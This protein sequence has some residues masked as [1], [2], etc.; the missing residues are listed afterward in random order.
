MDKLIVHA[1]AKIN[2]FLEVLDK[3]TD[4]YHNIETVFQSIDLHDTLIFKEQKAGVIN[5]SS[6]NKDL[7]LG[8]SNLIS[9]ACELL[10]KESGKN[11]GVDIQLIKRIPIGAGLAGGSADAGGTLIGLNEFWELGYSIGD[12]VELGKKLGADVPFCMIGGTALGKERGDSITKLKPLS[13]VYVVIAN[14]GFEVSTA[15]AYASLANLGLTRSKKNGN[16]IV[17]DINNSDVLAIA[18][19]LYNAFEQL[20]INEHPIIRE[21]KAEMQNLGALGALMTGSGPTVF[22]LTDDI[23]V[24]ENIKRKLES[25]VRFCVI[26]QTSNHSIIKA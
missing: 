8:S 26:S 10:L 6:D 3:R 2:L 12:L 1:N 22:A 24:A 20:V 15:Y 19:N 21:I 16:I 13:N 9:K 25:R 5:L 7:P 18:K 14:P 23:S 11:Y 17:D 4:G